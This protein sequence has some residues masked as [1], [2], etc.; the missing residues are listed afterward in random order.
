MRHKDGALNIARRKHP[1][2]V[3]PELANGHHFRLFCHGAVS[4]P[5]LFCMRAG[6][7][8][9]R[10]DPCI[11]HT[12]MR[13]RQSQGVLARS[14]IA[15]RIDDASN[16]S[17]EGGLNDGFTVG[18]ETSCVYVAVAIDEQTTCPFKIPAERFTRAT[19]RVAPT[20]HEC[21]D[22]AMVW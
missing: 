11:N 18:I 1:K 17:L 13:L 19:A 9:V 6:V 22:E 12:G 20:I 2:I 14:E 5:H 16:A 8:G 21:L 10:A 3:Q 7:M 15:A 4:R